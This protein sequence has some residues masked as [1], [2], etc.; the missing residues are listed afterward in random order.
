MKSQLFSVKSLLFSVK[1]LLFSVKSLLF[2]SGIPFFLWKVNFF[3][4]KYQL[5]FLC[6]VNFFSV[7]SQLFWRIVDEGTLF[8][9]FYSIWFFS[10]FVFYVFF[11][12]FLKIFLMFCRRNEFW[13]KICMKCVKYFMNSRFLLDLRQEEFCTFEIRLRRTIRSHSGQWPKW[14][15]KP[16][17]GHG[18]SRLF[19][20]EDS[21]FSVNFKFFLQFGAGFARRKTLFDCLLQTSPRINRL[22]WS[23]PTYVHLLLFPFALSHWN[24]PFILSTDWKRG[25]LL[26]C[27]VGRRKLRGATGD[28]QTHF[29]PA[30]SPGQLTQGKRSTPWTLVKSIAR[31][32]S[33]WKRYRRKEDLGRKDKYVHENDTGAKRIFWEK[34]NMFM[35]RYRRKED[36]S[37][38]HSIRKHSPK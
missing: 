19:C 5:F 16:I 21:F 23:S 13:W 29:G 38:K 27:P 37:R 12:F 30:H 34:T 35:K 2:S 24:R 10:N 25:T 9:P 7:K 33:S 36:P 18:K 31:Q 11:Q 32:I 20:P 14:I 26:A 22:R 1:S 8:I 15:T 28:E 4:L 17:K 3:L 6:K